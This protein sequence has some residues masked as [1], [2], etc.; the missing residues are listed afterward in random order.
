MYGSPGDNPIND[1][2]KHG[3]SGFGSPFDELIRQI[4]QH[5]YYGMVRKDLEAL[6]I[7]FMHAGPASEADRAAFKTELEGLLVKLE[8]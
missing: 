2:I 1:I 5:P 6:C 8:S 3:R 4:G 7:N